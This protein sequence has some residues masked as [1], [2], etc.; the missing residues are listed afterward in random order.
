[1]T[2][3][4]AIARELRAQARLPFTYAVRVLGAAALLLVALFFASHSG[5]WPN[6]GGRLFGWLNFTLF[7]F[8]WMIVPLIVADCISRER[9]E[10]TI[11]LLFLTPLKARDIVI[12]K[13]LVHGLRALTLWFAVIPIL[14]IPF[15]IGGLSRPELVLSVLFTF[16]SICWPPSFLKTGCA[17]RF[18]PGFSA[19]AL[20]ASSSAGPV[21]FLRTAWLSSRA[22]LRTSVVHQSCGPPGSRCT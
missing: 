9:R 7:V 11:G 1:M 4:P 13:G 15:L 17:P 21:I 16:S 22:P 14:A 5:L 6:T 20:P 18:S 19:S 8:V 12:A 2:V 3:L 10:G